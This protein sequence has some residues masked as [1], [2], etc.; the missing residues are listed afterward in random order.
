MAKRGGRLRLNTETIRELADQG[1]LAE[2]AGGQIFTIDA[3]PMTLHLNCIVPQPGISAI[4][5]TCVVCVG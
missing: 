2:A 4:R 1:G 3:C 5:N